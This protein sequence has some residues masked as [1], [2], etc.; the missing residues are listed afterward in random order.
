MDKFG[1][2]RQHHWKECLKISK[3]AKFESDLLKTNEDIASQTRTILQ[4][5]VWWWGGGDTNLPSTIQTSVNFCNFAKQ[6]LSTHS[7]GVSGL[8]L[9]LVHVKS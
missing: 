7:S 3:I 2:I 8:S 1:K 6:Y 5:F 9:L 4:M